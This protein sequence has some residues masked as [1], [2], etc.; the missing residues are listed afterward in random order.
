M[1]EFEE[2]TYSTVFTALRHPVCRRLLRV[3]S[4][5]ARTFTDL[6]N[7]FKVNGA[8][9][10]F[11][12]DAMKELICK[13]EDGKYGLSTMGEG[14]IALMERVEDPPK[15][16]STNP[17]HKNGRRLSILQSA[18]IC[19][20]II[21]LVSGTYLTSIPSVQTLYDVP[22]SLSSDT[23]FF[24]ADWISAQD[25]DAPAW[26]PGP[27]F[28]EIDGN[29]Y[30]NCY[31]V[32]FDSPNQLSNQLT[33]EYEADI[34]VNLKTNETAPSGLYN[35]TLTY[36]YHEPFDHIYSVKQWN[37]R[38]GFQPVE[39][40]SGI[41]FSTHLTLPYEV[42]GGTLPYDIRIDI[43]TNATYLRTS[44][45]PGYFLSVKASATAEFYSETHPY[46]SQGNIITTIG[47][48]VVA[49]ALMMHILS[50]LRK[51]T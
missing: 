43:W 8:V 27:D 21:L 1:G 20:A 13:T 12:L 45:E 41:A 2:E 7:S 42:G 30:D 37:Y 11:H 18:T 35:V 14:A 47:I 25:P 4:Q 5:G 9:L 50:L 16:V 49:I 26:V 22:A 38:G 34:H 19:I 32:L 44:A 40:S 23:Y 15:V 10:T 51:Q 48:I 33:E 36:L 17:S 6:Q 28:K 29:F 3:L 31:S 46:E 24:D 39:S